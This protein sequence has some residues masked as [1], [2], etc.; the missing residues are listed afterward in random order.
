MENDGQKL[1][2]HLNHLIT[3]CNDGKYGYETAAEDAGSAA[4]RSTFIAHS[5]ERGQF[6]DALKAEVIKLGG[7]PDEGGGPVGALHRAW[8]DVKTA[9]TSNDNKTV[10]SA[11]MTGDTAALNAYDEVL[12]DPVLTPE[13][14]VMLLNQ[15]REVEDALRETTVLHNTIE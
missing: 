3:I 11:C 14:R 5:T 12:N 9:L 15:R 4:L 7:I 6:A 1:I 8:I 2:D 13:L 10:L